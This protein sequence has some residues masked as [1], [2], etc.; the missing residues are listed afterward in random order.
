MEV[1]ITNQEQKNDSQENMIKKKEYLL[2]KIYDKYNMEIARKDRLESKAIGYYT[3]VG[4]SFAAFLVVEPI[5]LAQ[6]SLSKFSINDILVILNLLII[7]IYLVV[8][9]LLVAKLH[10]SYM[11]KT[12]EVFE[13]IKNWDTLVESQ[14]ESYIE[15]IKINLKDIIEKNEKSNDKIAKNIKSIN[16]LCLA[17][18]LLV[19]VAFIILFITH[20]V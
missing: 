4:I 20:L 5:L 10:Q 1:E 15:S 17:N 12:R 8:F 19:V 16:N 13:P 9:A 6:E 11:P 3:V 14:Y 18:M 7:I 2:E